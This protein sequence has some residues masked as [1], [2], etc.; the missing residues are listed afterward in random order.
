MTKK[1]AKYRLRLIYGFL[2]AAVIF[3]VAGISCFVTGKLLENRN[4]EAAISIAPTSDYE[5][6][7]SAYANA[8]DLAPDRLEAY[9]LML[10]LYAQDNLFTTQES[11]SFLR[12]YNGNHL[13][14][15]QDAQIELD[16]Q[17]GLLYATAYDGDMTARLRM[18]YPFFE[19]SARSLDP[20]DPDY[21]TVV[22]YYHMGQYYTEYIWTTKVLEVPSQDMIKLVRQMT[23]SVKSVDEAKSDSPHSRIQFYSA[24]CDL[25]YDQRDIL[26]VTVSYEEVRGLL[27]LIFEITPYIAQHQE[28]QRLMIELHG[29][30]YSYR[31]M[32]DRAYARQEGGNTE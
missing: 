29:K 20:K 19:R 10:T 13:K 5:T 17:T 4:Y 30:E 18:A 15:S 27:D 14:L 8:I 26:A 23:A 24:V 1:E 12:I 11:N 9:S 6:C 31:E 16:K 28:T 3:V 2:Y 22:C 25:L 21:A 7:A 32:I